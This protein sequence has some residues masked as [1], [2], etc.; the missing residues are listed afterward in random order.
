MF[1]RSASLISMAIAVCCHLQLSTWDRAMSRALSCCV[2]SAIDVRMQ[3]C[4]IVLLHLCSIAATLSWNQSVLRVSLV[5]SVPSGPTVRI[6]KKPW[7]LKETALFLLHVWWMSNTCF[8]LSWPNVLQ[9]QVFGH[10][11]FTAAPTH[12]KSPLEISKITRYLSIFNTI[13]LELA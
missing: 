11:F 5:R 9:K 8:I 2:C 10:L 3:V 7:H 13:V 4:H 6:S 12:N 1:W